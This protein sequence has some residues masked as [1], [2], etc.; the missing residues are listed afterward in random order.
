MESFT[1]HDINNIFEIGAELSTRRLYD[2]IMDW[3]ELAVNNYD[4]LENLDEE[5]LYRKVYDDSVLKKMG[6]SKRDFTNFME[7]PGDTT[8]PFRNRSTSPT[9]RRSSV[10]SRSVSPINRNKF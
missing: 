4:W 5:D 3:M 1:K 7:Y 2:E 6:I 10:S 8:N 9:L